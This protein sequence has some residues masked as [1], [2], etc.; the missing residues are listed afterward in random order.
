[1]EAEVAVAALLARTGETEARD[2]MR[3]VKTKRTKHLLSSRVKGRRGPTEVQSKVTDRR[4][5]KGDVA[6][7]E[8]V[9]VVASALGVTTVGR[10]SLIVT[11][12]TTRGIS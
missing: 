12:A 9:E 8:A 10:E 5:E 11:A 1:V 2:E 4:G 6:G 7:V 3:P